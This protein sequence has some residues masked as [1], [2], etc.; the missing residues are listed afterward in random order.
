MKKIAPLAL[1]AVLALPL[2]A[3][4]APPAAPTDAKTDAKVGAKTDADREARRAK[5]KADQKKMEEAKTP[6][7]Q[8]KARQEMRE[9]FEKEVAPE[10]RKRMAEAQAANHA[11][12]QEDL[13]MAKEEFAAI[14][15][16]LTRVEQL[17]RQKGIIDLPNQMRGFGGPGGGRGGRRG[18]GEGFDP[19]MLLGDAPMEASVQ[20]CQ[21]AR[22]A[23]KALLDD[24]QANATEVAAAT[25]RL[26]KGMASFQAAMDRAQ[27]ELKGVLTPRQEAQLVENGVL[28]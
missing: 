20:E 21:D 18:G 13:G 5:W 22:K 15:P 26:R 27:A 1:L 28:D 12:M 2:F 24:K 19:K 4:D 17:R 16:M 10:I 14:E 3:A 25:A 9:R 6:E 7:E 11:K 23:L 8:E